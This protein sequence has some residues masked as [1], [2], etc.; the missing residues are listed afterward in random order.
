[1]ND[2]EGAALGTKVGVRLGDGDG[3]GDSV[4]T[5]LGASE[6]WLVVGASLGELD[7]RRER[8]GFCVSVGISEG[9]GDGA[10]ESV[11]AGEIVGAQSSQRSLPRIPDPDKTIMN[12]NR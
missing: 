5:S 3:A 10:G 6:G 7:G 4:G 11:G 1:M 8:E 2:T 12:A 9:D